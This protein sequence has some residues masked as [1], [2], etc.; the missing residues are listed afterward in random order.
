MRLTETDYD[1]TAYNGVYVHRR[2]RR[3]LGLRGA[4]AR[5]YATQPLGPVGLRAGRIPAVRY[6][7]LRC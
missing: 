7:A 4:A 6:L 5:R 2:L 1:A 3:R